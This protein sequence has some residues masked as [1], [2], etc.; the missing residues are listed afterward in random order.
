[1]LVVDPWHWL[2]EEGDLPT[3]DARARRQALR[4]AR[5]IEAGGPLARGESRETLVECTKR[6]GRKACLGL[7]HVE[8]TEQDEIY[9]FCPLCRGDELTIHNWQGTRWA[10]GLS[11]P[12]RDDGVV[13]DES[14]ATS[15]DPEPSG[16][17]E[18]R[19]HADVS[20]APLPELLQRQVAK[21]VAEYCEG[22]I[23]AHVRHQ[24]RMSYRIS[25]HSVTLFEER[26]SFL[27]PT[28]WVD[29]SIAQLRYETGA[30]RWTLFWSDADGRWCVYERLP[31]NKS[32]DALLREIDEDAECFFWG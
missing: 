10:Q 20:E 11:A 22:R 17:P 32:L 29:N 23:P 28:Q 19:G 31:S 6:P 7:M 26:Q 9:A 2:S 4:V 12:V 30:Q 1:M 24:I 8:K 18:P 16:D 27:D 25:G 3:D 15:A 14:A 5:L 13:H 21:K